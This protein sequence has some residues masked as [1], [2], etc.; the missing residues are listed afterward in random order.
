MSTHGG[1]NNQ[2]MV[3]ACSKPLVIYRCVVEMSLQNSHEMHW[4]Q[5]Q[6]LC[7]YTCP[8][9]FFHYRGLNTPTKANYEIKGLWWLTVQGHSL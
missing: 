2:S 1:R 9:F 5:R 6:I 7:E 4:A 8:S 3:C